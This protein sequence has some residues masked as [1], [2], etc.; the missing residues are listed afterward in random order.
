MFETQLMSANQGLSDE[1]IREETDTF[2]FG[3]SLLVDCND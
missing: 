3:V 1:G 2:M